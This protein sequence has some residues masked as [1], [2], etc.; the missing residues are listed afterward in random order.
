MS[1]YSTIQL[2]SERTQAMSSGLGGTDRH[3]NKALVN[4]QPPQ[5]FEF[6][7]AEPDDHEGDPF[8]YEFNMEEELR[9]L[10]M[11]K[12]LEERRAWAQRHQ[13][14]EE[15]EEDDEGEEE[16]TDVSFSRSQTSKPFSFPNRAPLKAQT[17]L[18]KRMKTDARLPGGALTGGWV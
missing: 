4:T 3:P 9:R 7:Q 8:F 18:L 2:A 14:R 16:E 12:E 17:V 13:L 11:M 1:G 10:E 6:D 5:Q 15:D